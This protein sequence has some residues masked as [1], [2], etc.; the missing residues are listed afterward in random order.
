MALVGVSSKAS[1][2]VAMWMEGGKELVV[3]L[4]LSVLGKRYVSIVK[5]D[6]KNLLIFTIPG[7]LG[8]QSINYHFNPYSSTCL[9]AVILAVGLRAATRTYEN[10]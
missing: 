4:V 5:M 9:G 2:V 6:E 10:R 8:L 3:V 7:W 1:L